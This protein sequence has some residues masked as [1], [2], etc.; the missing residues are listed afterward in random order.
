MV[1][2]FSLDSKQIVIGFEVKVPKIVLRGPVSTSKEFI[3]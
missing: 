1:H 3:A 2:D